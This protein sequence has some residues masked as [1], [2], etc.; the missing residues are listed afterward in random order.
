[1]PVDVHLRGMLG[2]LKHIG[3]NHCSELPFGDPGTAG[4]HSALYYVAFLRMGQIGI[5]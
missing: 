3:A 5:L 2:H 4:I 1:M